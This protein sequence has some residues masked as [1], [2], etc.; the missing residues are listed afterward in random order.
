M[1]SYCRY[2]YI[3]IA[4][5]GV[6]RI[7]LMSLNLMVWLYSSQSESGLI[8]RWKKQS[9]QQGGISFSTNQRF[10]LHFCP[11]PIRMRKT[12]HHM[13][14]VNKRMGLLWTELFCKRFFGFLSWNWYMLFLKEFSSTSSWRFLINCVIA[15]IWVFKFVGSISMFR[16]D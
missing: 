16:T 11:K 3:H 10:C 15:K 9:D 8:R 7:G 2:A 1:F 14:F 4:I 6:C 5:K 12:L 13:K